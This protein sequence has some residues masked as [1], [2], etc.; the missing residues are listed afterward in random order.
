MGT[1]SDWESIHYGLFRKTINLVSIKINHLLHLCCRFDPFLSYGTNNVIFWISMF[2]LSWIDFFFMI[3]NR[4]LVKRHHLLPLSFQFR[5]N[6][7]FGVKV[8]VT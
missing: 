3:N 2:G 4:T 6:P 5:S 8:E 1:G 7:K